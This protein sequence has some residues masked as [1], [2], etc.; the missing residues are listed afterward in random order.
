MNTLARVLLVLSLVSLCSYMYGIWETLI[1]T[2]ENG[3]K[4]TYMFEFPQF[5]VRIEILKIFLA[6]HIKDH[7]MHIQDI[8]N[9][10]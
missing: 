3:C 2:E 4:M 7:Y 9:Q 5:V 6:L 10:F 1:S 8:I